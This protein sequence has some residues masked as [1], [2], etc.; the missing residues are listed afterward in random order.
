MA[1]EATDFHTFTRLAMHSPDEALALAK[2]V[3]GLLL[4]RSGLDETPLHYLVVED[5]VK[6]VARLIEAGASVNVVNFC[7]SSPLI[8]AVKCRYGDMSRL[9]LEHHADT[10]VENNIGETAL[11]VAALQMNATMFELLLPYCPGDINGFFD[12]LA[13]MEL[14]ERPADPIQT[15]C[16]ALGLKSRFDDS[17]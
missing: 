7:G 4:L 5:R 8:E 2:A 16:R 15:Q 11:S 1:V 9:L 17:G 14:L 3:P 12:D 6:P 13:A 10:A